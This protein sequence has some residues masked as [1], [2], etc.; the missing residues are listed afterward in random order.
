MNEEHLLL[1]HLKDVE[2]VTAIVC[3]RHGIRDADAEDF[4]SHVKLKLIENDCAI[5]RK[6]EGRSQFSTYATI[7]VGRL[8]KDYRNHLLGKW[9]PSAAAK[10]LGATAVALERLVQCDRRPVEEAI[11]EL[12]RAG[13]DRAFLETFA[14]DVRPRTGRRMVGIDSV[15]P[16]LLVPTEDVE[17]AAANRERHR[18]AARASAVVRDAVAALPKDDRQLFRLH[19]EGGLTVA[20]I[21]RA[22]RREQKP[23]YRRLRRA[24]DWIRTRLE[25]AGIRRVDAEELIRARGC[26]LDFGFADGTAPDGPSMIEEAGGIGDGESEE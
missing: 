7:V 13:A 18:T 8:L 12:V 16:M 22:L 3:R 5:L 10:R 1:A 19:F 2:R 26:D 25:E 11:T 15:E 9:R 20:E 4:A 17:S 21:A 14:A 6:F 24:L 23:I